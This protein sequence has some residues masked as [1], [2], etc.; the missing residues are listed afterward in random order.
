MIPSQ[1]CDRLIIPSQICDGL[2]IPSQVCDGNTIPSQFCN[3]FLT[4]L[5]RIAINKNSLY[6]I[7]FLNI[8][9]YKII[10]KKNLLRKLKLI[11]QL[12]GIVCDLINA[13]ESISNIQ[14]NKLLQ[15]AWIKWWLK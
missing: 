4:D 1:I 10:E 14:F 3:Q 6:Y 5:W 13:I 7:L 9:K 2:I 12:I 11:Q 8:H 15:L